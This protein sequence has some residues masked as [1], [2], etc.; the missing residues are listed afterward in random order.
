MAQFVSWTREDVTAGVQT[1]KL[2]IESKEFDQAFLSDREIFLTCINCKFR[3][4][5]AAKKLIK[6]TTEMR[7]R[8]T[9]WT[10]YSRR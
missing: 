9:F 10:G 2:L 6:W 4:E 1:K 3:P 7:Q 5:K 8:D